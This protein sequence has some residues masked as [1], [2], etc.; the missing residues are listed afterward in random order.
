M[1]IDPIW[2]VRVQPT[3]SHESVGFQSMA[4][5]SCRMGTFQ[6]PEYPEPA[7]DLRAVRVGL[8]LSLRQ[9]ADAL[10]IAPV[11]VA[12]IER[13]RQRPLDW[14][15]LVDRLRRVRP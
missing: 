12:D 6:V 14:P 11:D 4:D 8:G 13:G 1:K 9:V 10:G 7:V 5:G 3:G 2:T 15:A